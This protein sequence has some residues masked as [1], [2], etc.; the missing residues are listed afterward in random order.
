MKNETSLFFSLKIDNFQL[1]Y[2]SISELRILVQIFVKIQQFSRRKKIIS[3]KNTCH[4]LFT[5]LLMKLTDN[6]WF[7]LKKNKFNFY[8]CWNSWYLNSL[9]SV[10]NQAKKEK[11]YQK[12]FKR[13]KNGGGGSPPFPRFY[14]TFTMEPVKVWILR[15]RLI[16]S[17]YMLRVQ[18]CALCSVQLI[19]FLSC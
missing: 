2:L 10:V 7:G 16:D 11:K 8:L 15:R 1:L 18:Y 5:V 3:Q 4:S 13:L 6:N 12:S 19:S 9:G 14:T 17:R